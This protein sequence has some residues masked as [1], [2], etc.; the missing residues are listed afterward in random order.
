MSGKT[1]MLLLYGILLMTSCSSTDSRQVKVEGQVEHLGR[2]V[3]QV[4][5]YID[6]HTLGYDTIYTTESGKFK[7]QVLGTAEINPITLYFP[8]SKSWTTLFA[9]RGDIIHVSGDIESVDLMTIKGGEV[10]DDL[11]RFKREISALYVERQHIIEGKYQNGGQAIE[12]R[13]AEINLL[14]K[15]KAKEFIIE[16]P[17][18]VASVILIQDFFYQEYDPSTSELLSLLNSG[19]RNSHIAQRLI[20]GMSE[21]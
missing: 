13:L 3:I 5:Y 19:A 12:Q 21:W 17:S 15:R 16:N 18:S 14:L 9:K 20:Q 10:N 4:S 6:D 2:T 1:S 7:F 8:D 11:T